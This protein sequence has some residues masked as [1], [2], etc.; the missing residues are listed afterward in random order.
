MLNEALFNIILL[1]HQENTI[2]A[3]L[4][5]NKNSEIFNGHFPGQPVLPGACMLQIIKE[6]LESTLNI[7]FRLKKAEQMK[8]LTLVD[9]Q[10][11][12]ILLLKLSYKSEGNENVDVTANLIAQKNIC[13]KFK[14]TFIAR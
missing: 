10:I 5:I 12:N 9:P 14:G 3:T 7:H 2:K 6:V 13:F 11:N 8:F 1:D 4:E